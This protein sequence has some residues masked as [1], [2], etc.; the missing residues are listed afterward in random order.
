[1]GIL[2][3]QEGDYGE[4]GGVPV[5]LEVEIE[6]DGSVQRR[7]DRLNFA[8]NADHRGVLQRVAGILAGNDVGLEIL[9]R[10]GDPQFEVSAG[11]KRRRVFRADV[12]EF[13][14][15]CARGGRAHAEKSFWNGSGPTNMIVGVLGAAAEELYA[16]VN[17][18]LGSVNTT[19]L[20]SFGVPLLAF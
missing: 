6:G 15:D 13:F 2:L 9:F 5:F 11:R 20:N 4:I 19:V 10:N 3:G 12:E 7:L 1:M 17:N 18:H 8:E 16:A 14:V